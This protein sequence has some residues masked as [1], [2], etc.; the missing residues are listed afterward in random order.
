MSTDTNIITSACETQ[1]SWDFHPTYESRGMLGYCLAWFNWL[2]NNLLGTRCSSVAPIGAKLDTNA[3][4]SACEVQ[5]S[6]SHIQVTDPEIWMLIAYSS[7][8]FNWLVI[9]LLGLKKPIRPMCMKL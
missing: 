1:I 6:R 8:Q 5:V 7:S 2:A 9:G 3:N 4:A